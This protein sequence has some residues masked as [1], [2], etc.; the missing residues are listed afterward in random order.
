MPDC[1]ICFSKVKNF[2]MKC[3]CN[4]CRGCMFEWVKEE[5]TSTICIT[6]EFFRCPNNTCKKD[7]SK[8]WV[9]EMLSFS[10]QIQISEILLKKYLNSKN[11]IQ[12]CPKENCNFAGYIPSERSLCSI[13]LREKLKC[14]SCGTTWN[15][16]SLRIN[17]P[18]ES[19]NIMI[20]FLN[21]IFLILN[22][23][24]NTIKDEISSLRIDLLYNPCISCKRPIYKFEGCQHMTC[25]CKEQ[26]CYICL[27][28]WKNHDT[29]T[30]FCQGKQDLYGFSGF[31]AFITVFAHLLATFGFLWKILYIL[32]IQLAVCCFAFVIFSGYIGGFVFVFYVTLH[33]LEVN[34]KI[35]SKIWIPLKTLAFAAFFVSP[36]ILWL[37]YQKYIYFAYFM[38]IFLI[39]L[40]I[41]SIVAGII[42]LGRLIFPKFRLFVYRITG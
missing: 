42:F 34:H 10:Q 18:K 28:E 26:F 24:I 21:K 32:L 13:I 5:N 30:M 19:K 7:F 35:S 33:E 8:S 15:E 31:F 9:Y 23:F 40:F 38:H 25:I 12:K 14:K 1:L 16:D 20:N 29:Q 17:S 37:L 6:T 27:R 2:K 3:G 4:I 22:Y 41:A 11:D 36:Y 39:E